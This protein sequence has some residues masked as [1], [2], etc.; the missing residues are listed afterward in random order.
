MMEEPLAYTDSIKNKEDLGL[1]PCKGPGDRLC[2]VKKEKCRVLWRADNMIG[3]PL[4]GN[5]EGNPR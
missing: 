2:S 1:G 4:E 3:E 5:K